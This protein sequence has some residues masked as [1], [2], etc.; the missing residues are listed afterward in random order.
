MSSSAISWP[1]EHTALR[2]RI[3]NDRIERLISIYIIQLMENNVINMITQLLSADYITHEHYREV[4]S[5]LAN[6]NSSLLTY[7]PE[8]ERAGRDSTNTH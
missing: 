3:Q 6:Q 1:D 5:P 4:E 2:V 7:E 8:R